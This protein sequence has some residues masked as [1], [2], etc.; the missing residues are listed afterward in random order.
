MKITIIN[1]N[2]RHGNTWHCTDMLKQALVNIDNVEI[3]EYFLPKDM[4]HFCY[5]CFSCFYNGEDTCPH[6]ANMKPINNDLLNA[7]VVILTS[8]VYAFDVSGAMKAFLDHLSYTWMS[9]RPNPKMFN[10]VGVII[11]TTAG[12]GLGHAS[13]TMHNSLKYWGV[14]RIYSCK[15]AVSASKWEEVTEKKKRQIKN[16]TDKLAKKIAHTVHN[17][18]KLKSPMFRSIFFWMMRGMMKGNTWN[19]R[20]RKHW[21]EQGWLNSKKASL[22]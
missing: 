6:A 1:G 22:L 3:I 13:K 18:D 4:P 10:K 15:Y 21:E 5:G 11:S 12:M 14:K 2:P 19:L 9:H 8:P 20:D 17:A 16:D 7:D